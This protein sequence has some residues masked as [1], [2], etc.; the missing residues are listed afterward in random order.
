MLD[1]EGKLKFEVIPTH[2]NMY[3]KFKEQYN[4]E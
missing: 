4:K 2:H 1:K 3:K